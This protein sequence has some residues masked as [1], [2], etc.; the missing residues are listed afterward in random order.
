MPYG[1]GPLIR[2]ALVTASPWQR[3]LIG[4]AMVGRR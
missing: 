2:Q 1:T 3:Y 4:I